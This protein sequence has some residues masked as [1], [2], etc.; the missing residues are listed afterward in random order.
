MGHPFSLP[1]D[2]SSGLGRPV[3]GRTTPQREEDGTMGSHL[4]AGLAQRLLKGACLQREDLGLQRA[5]QLL[6]RPVGAQIPVCWGRCVPRLCTEVEKSEDGRKAD[7][8][9]NLA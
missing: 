7:L 6:S 2:A 9:R 8:Y 5:V 4:A 3:G 1:R